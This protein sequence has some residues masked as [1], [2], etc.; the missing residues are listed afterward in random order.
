MEVYIL[1][2]AD[3]EMQEI[4]AVLETAGCG[5][6]WA[7]HEGKRC[8]PGDAYRA[9][10]T[11]KV[12]PWAAE[13]R[14]VET[15]HVANWWR[16]EYDHHRPG[17]PGYG[18]PPARYREG[19][20]L[21]QVMAHLGVEP[22]PRQLG[23]MAADHCLGAAYRGE[24]PGVDPEA[25]MAWRAESRARFQNRP[26][27]DVLAD[28]EAA[29]HILCSATSV[30]IGGTLVADLRR[31]SVPELPEAAV[32]EEIPFLATVRERDGREKVVIQG[33]SDAV[34]AAF[35]A[36]AAAFG[37]GDTYGDPARGFAGVYLH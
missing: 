4:A 15:S 6:V 36:G 35:L 19:S 32:R 21:G 1:G 23:I 30:L 20:S 14:G 8:V 12:I 25:L 27:A 17:D 11:D 5:W 9:D 24:C 10:S 34:I 33:A 13:A 26:V 2:A 18:L 28:V 16:S 29:R 31:Q 37:A 7:T 22:T 3:P